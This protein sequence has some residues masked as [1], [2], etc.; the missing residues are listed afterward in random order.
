AALADEEVARARRENRDQMLLV[1]DVDVTYDGTQVLF[2]VSCNVGAGEIVAL[3]GTNGAGKSTLLRAIVGLQEASN[4][5]IFV[6]GADITHAPPHE[7][8]RRGIVM[9]PGGHAVFPTLTVREN[10]TTAAGAAELSDED[11]RARIEEVLELFPALRERY[12]QQAGN[13]SGGEQQMLALGQAF[14]WRPRLLMIDELSL[15]LAP[16]VVDLLVRTVRKIHEQGTT[17]MLVEQSV[18]VA[19]TIAERAI[20]MEK[21]EIR[22]DGPVAELMRRPDLLRA[23]FMGGAL[24]TGGG[25]APKRKRALERESVIRAENVWVRYGGVEALRG[26]SIEAAAGEIVGIIGP[27]G[28]GKTTLFD[29][30]AGH[31]TAAEGTVTLAGIDVT[32]TP[33]H[34]RALSGLGR[35]FQDARLFGSLTVRECIA[36]AFERSLRVRNPIAAALY[37]PKA[38]AD[39]R[40]IRRKVERLVILLGL[41][42]YADKFVH[43]LSTGTRRAVDIACIMASEPSAVLLDEPSSGLAQAEAEALAPLLTTLV[44]ETNCAMLVIEHDLP[45]VSS[46]AD[47]LVAMDLGTT[48]ATGAPEEVLADQR[49]VSS[50]LAATDDIIKRSDLQAVTRLQ[51]TSR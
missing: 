42:A 37:L 45:L 44:R 21:G 11:A 41:R 17:V 28:A 3:L 32:V 15:G 24:G 6:D 31:A 13:L 10:L 50:Y 4:G 39:E 16:A 2:G 43:E 40:R 12:G 18:N 34:A 8:A 49:V 33:P 1:R 5:A 27:N 26:A 23:V 51:T 46:I 38:R 48:I 19:L 35:S 36:L 47:R 9:V 22:F 20:F 30:L 14:L 29:V 7:N 25:R